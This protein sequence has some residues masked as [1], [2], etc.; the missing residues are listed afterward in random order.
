MPVRQQEQQ[1]LPSLPVPQQ[2]PQRPDVSCAAGGAAVSNPS[3]YIPNTDCQ[4]TPSNAAFNP[5]CGIDDMS[6]CIPLC[7]PL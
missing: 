4:S 5:M 7:I 3:T 6:P 1:Q 2:A